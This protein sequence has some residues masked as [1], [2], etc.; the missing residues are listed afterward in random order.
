LLL[1]IIAIPAVCSRCAEGRRSA[2]QPFCRDA[3]PAAWSAAHAP[4]LSHGEPLASV[5]SLHYCECYSAPEHLRPRR[6]ARQR[7]RLLL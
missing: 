6:T 7:P 5:W 4:A 3:S 2:T 1:G